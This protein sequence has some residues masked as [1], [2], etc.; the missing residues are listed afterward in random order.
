MAAEDY[1]DFDQ[2]DDDDYASTYERRPLNRGIPRWY[3]PQPINC[4]YCG[5]GGFHWLNLNAKRFDL[6]PLWR[7]VGKNNEIH[8]CQALTVRPTPWDHPS[9]AKAVATLELQQMETRLRNEY[10]VYKTI[11]EKAAMPKDLIKHVNLGRFEVTGLNHHDY[12][13]FIKY[14]AAGQ[15]VELH[16]QPTNPVDVDAVEVRFNGEQIGW[17]P[18][19][20]SAEKTLIA[21]MLRAEVE[22][23]TVVVEHTP[24]RSLHVAI[25]LKC[26]R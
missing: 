23:T 17:L 1:V 16:A 3:A 24:G 19:A 13:L 7:L 15:H 12:A 14:I 5:K 18:R 2:W 6:T 8:H 10:S 4:K 26:D 9:L 25:Y 20:R 22:F 11:K 21:K